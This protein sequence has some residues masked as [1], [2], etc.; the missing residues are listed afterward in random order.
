MKKRKYRPRK[1]KELDPLIP[2]D[3]L[4]SV[5][6]GLMAVPKGRVTKPKSK[7]RKRRRKGASNSR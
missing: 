3:D 1:P 4:K 5:V 6:A 7:S 2:L